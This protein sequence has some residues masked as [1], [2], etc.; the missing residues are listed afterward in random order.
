MSQPGEESKEEAVEVSTATLD[1][2]D[3]YVAAIKSKDGN[4]ILKGVEAVRELVSAE[5]VPPMEEMLASGVVPILIDMISNKFDYSTD[6]TDKALEDDIKGKLQFQASWALSDMAGGDEEDH[7]KELVDMGYIEGFMSL[8]KNATNPEL[9]SQAVSGLGNIAFAS[10]QFRDQILHLGALEYILKN[11]DTCPLEIKRKVVSSLRAIYKNRTISE[12]K[13]VAPLLQYLIGLVAQSTDIETIVDALCIIEQQSGVDLSLR[14]DAILEA[15]I[16]SVLFKLLQ[17]DCGQKN[18]RQVY[19]SLYKN[20][21]FCIDLRCVVWVV[22][23]FFF[24]F[25]LPMGKAKATNKLHAELVKAALLIIGSISSGTNSQTQKLIERGI[26]DIIDTL[27]DHSDKKVKEQA[28]WILSNVIPT[29]EE[30]RQL[31]LFFEKKHLIKTIVELSRQRNIPPVRKEAGWCLINAMSSA[32]FEQMNE[33]VNAGFIEAM[34]ELLD[35]R[36][37]KII[38]LALNALDSCFDKYTQHAN[39]NINPNPLV[40]KMEELGGLNLLEDIL[41]VYDGDISIIKNFIAKYWP[42]DDSLVTK[43]F[44]KFDKSIIRKAIPFFTNFALKKTTL[45]FVLKYINNIYYCTIIDI[46]GNENEIKSDIN[47][48]F[49]KKQK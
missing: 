40:Q 49:T 12:W 29:L 42:E 2:L 9:F 46:N 5:V 8:L 34:V 45:H 26:L 30:D 21:T 16:V 31:H 37:N 48:Q 18:K 24:F 47:V 20:V 7:K 25:F 27:L 10:V 15:G 23:N 1:D 14:I 43:I 11:I 44:L 36:T 6:T 17:Q 22:S 28:C 3:K 32:S 38:P 19:F 33:L 13:Q 4:K 35:T 41:E 39:D